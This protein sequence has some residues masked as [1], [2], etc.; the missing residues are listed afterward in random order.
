MA[1]MEVQC[2][3]DLRYV[4]L[5]LNDILY[6]GICRLC[7]NRNFLH[8]GK[9]LTNQEISVKHDILATGKYSELVKL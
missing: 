8:A 7:R 5:L 3:Y 1:L 9:F 4:S 2:L 6:W